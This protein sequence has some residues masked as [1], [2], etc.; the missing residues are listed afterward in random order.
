MPVFRVSYKLINIESCP[1][2]L[3][4]PNGFFNRIIEAIEDQK[5]VLQ[6]GDRE[7]LVDYDGKKNLHD[8]I[9]EKLQ[10]EIFDKFDKECA[11]TNEGK[12]LMLEYCLSQVVYKDSL[13]VYKLDKDETLAVYKWINDHMSS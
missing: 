5:G 13:V 9:V 1:K 8:E 12:Q 4:D 2:A 6:I 7:L 3:K 10:K 11:V